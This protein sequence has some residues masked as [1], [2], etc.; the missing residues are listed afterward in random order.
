MHWPTILF[1]TVVGVLVVAVEM[2][3]RRRLRPMLARGCAGRAW[4]RAFPGA[5]AGE[6]RAFLKIFVD[7]FGL[8]R[9]HYLA[10]GPADRIMDVY[11]A[12][13][14]P[15]WPVADNMEL[16]MLARLLERDYRVSLEAMWR[17]DIT[18]GD[19]FGR[20]VGGGGEGAKGT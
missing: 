4:R 11:R 5:S 7:G 9:K 18:L 3:R 6:I 16:E 12:I 8:R 2:G 1:W 13:N 10:F 15:I 17:D 19:V 20:C 14:L